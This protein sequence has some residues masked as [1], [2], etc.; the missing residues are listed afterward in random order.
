VI[1]VRDEKG[2]QLT[3]SNNAEALPLTVAIVH[4]GSKA[5]IGEQ[6]GTI[7]FSRLKK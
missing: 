3:T 2:K 1:R 4:R 6:N 5:V 7:R